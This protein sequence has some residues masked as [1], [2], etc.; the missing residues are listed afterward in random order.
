M[1]FVS[2]VLQGHCILHSPFSHV[3]MQLFIEWASCQ[4]PIL[5]YFL[6][7]SKGGF[8]VARP[9]VPVASHFHHLPPND[10]LLAS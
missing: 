3:H 10:L 6:Q 9:I 8:G 5:K 4:L 1:Y 7:P 2:L